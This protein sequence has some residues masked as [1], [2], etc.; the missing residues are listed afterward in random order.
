MMKDTCCG[1]ALYGACL[2][3]EC[4]YVLTLGSVMCQ[5]ALPYADQHC[6]LQVW[7]EP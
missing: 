5:Q 1:L 7:G 4:L 3:V 2:S 6:C